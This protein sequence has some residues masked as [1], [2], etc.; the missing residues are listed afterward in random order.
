M[1]GGPPQCFFLSEFLSVIYQTGNRKSQR[2]H[3]I[4]RLWGPPWGREVGGGGGGGVKMLWIKFGFV[5]R[6]ASPLKR[7]LG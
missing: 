4:C 6:D 2:L 5:A 3:L 1:W 7:M